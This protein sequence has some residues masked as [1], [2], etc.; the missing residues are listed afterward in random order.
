MY[1]VVCKNETLSHLSIVFGTDVVFFKLLNIK[2]DLRGE[3]QIGNE[4]VSLIWSHSGLKS[5]CSIHG[6]ALQLVDYSFNNIQRIEPDCFSLYENL[7][8]NKIKFLNPITF[9]GLTKLI[10]LD[11][12]KNCLFHLF[13]LPNKLKILNISHNNFVRIRLNFRQLNIQMIFTN[14]YRI[15]CLVNKLNVYCSVNPKKCKTIL[16]S[17]GFRVA[18]IVILLLVVILNILSLIL[19]KYKFK[20]L[21]NNEKSLVFDA[22]LS[23]MNVNNVATA[24]CVLSILAASFQYEK[25]YFSGFDNWKKHIICKICGFIFNVGYLHSVL[26]V[27]LLTF[28]RFI[29]VKYPLKSYLKDVEMLRKIQLK[30]FI[31]ITSMYALSSVFYHIAEQRDEMPTALCM[32]VGGTNSSIT[33]RCVTLC[34]VIIQTGSFISVTIFYSFIVQ[35]LRK[36]KCTTLNRSKSN[37]DKVILQAVLICASKALCYLPSS[38]IYIAS[39]VMEGFPIDVLM[40]NAMIVHSMELLMNPI[41]YCLIP[42]NK[43]GNYTKKQIQ[44]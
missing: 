42:W 24:I 43:K 4:T 6:K 44:C 37:N 21:P 10:K 11:I 7:N 2:N 32:Y 15:C 33:I 12:S 27:N 30:L 38:T 31:C 18:F 39:V 17:I 23:T 40:W 41:I 5:V 20:S 9:G 3:L 26:L 19:R 34:L 8:N 35:V 14:D 22:N 13:S 25:I 1:A 36:Q 16:Y 29:A 28:Y